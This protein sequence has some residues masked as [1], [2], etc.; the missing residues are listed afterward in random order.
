MGKTLGQKLRLLRDEKKLTQEE[1]SRRLHLAR[2]A[3]ANYENDKRTPSYQYLVRFADFYDIRVD[4]LLREDFTGSPK[5]LQGPAQT[6]FREIGLL[7]PAT[8][9][10][11]SEYVHYRVVKSTAP[12]DTQSS[13][14]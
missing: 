1:L 13:P 11:L 10:E 8:Q 2:A 3:Y 4:Y 6:L 14:V 5:N 7:D 12:T 9:K